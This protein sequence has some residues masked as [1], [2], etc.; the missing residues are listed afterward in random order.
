MVADRVLVHKGRLALGVGDLGA[1]E[2]NLL[3]VAVD[4]L[5]QRA[6]RAEDEVVGGEAGVLH[7]LQDVAERF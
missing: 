1:L 6:A 5:Q 3:G 4:L 2:R 7:R